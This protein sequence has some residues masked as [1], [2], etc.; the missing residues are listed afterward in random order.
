MIQFWKI[1]RKNFENPKRVVINRGGSSSWKTW[2]LLRMILLWLLNGQIDNS[3]KIFESGVLSVVRKYTSNLTRSVLRDFDDIIFSEIPENISRKI[4]INKT[5]KTYKFGNRTVEFIGIDDPQKARWPRREILYCNEANE[6]TYEDFRQLA[7]RT[8]YRIFIDFNPDDEDIWINTEIEQKRQHEEGDV[9]V[10]VSTYRDNP[11]LHPQI[12]KE[13]ERLEKTDPVWWQ[14][15]WLW[16]YWRL[17]GRIFDFKEIS[18]VPETA[19]LLGYGLDFGFTNDPTALVAVYEYGE[20]LVLDEIVY[21]S[22]LTNTD[23]VRKFENASIA[24]NTEIWAD[25][26]EPKS[27]EEIY[28]SGYNVH[29][30]EK[31]PDSVRFWIDMMRQFPLYVTARSL[32][33]R[34]EGKKYI[35][36]K[37]KNGKSLNVPID[38]FNHAI[39]AARYLIMSKKKQQIKKRFRFDSL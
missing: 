10:I 31:W 12:I 30:V 9:A 17:E 23:I 33:L 2:T 34:K 36:K 16:Q 26:S 32:N 1:Y 6:L 14:V 38:E 4:E 29:A 3:G 37:D 15:Y 24:K 5:E 11:F 27:I 18:E 28:R 19:K 8:N 7:M 21:E 35:W 22:G 25:S 20:A 39:D 13:L